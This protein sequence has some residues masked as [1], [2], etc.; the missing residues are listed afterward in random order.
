[1]TTRETAENGQ[2]APGAWWLA[3]IL[4]GLYPVLSL[5]SVNID[6]FAYGDTFRPVV[7]I[8]VVM[9]FLGTIFFVGLRDRLKASLLLSAFTFLFFSYGHAGEI[10]DRF[11][12]FPILAAVLHQMP[13]SPRF[14]LFS[15]CF[16]LF[17]A[18]AV[19]LARLRRNP[20]PAIVFANVVAAVL[21]CLPAVSILQTGI[22]NHGLVREIPLPP[23][24]PDPVKAALAADPALA[25]PKAGPT[26][27]APD[28]YYIILDAYG[29]ADVLEKFYGFS[30]RPFEQAMRRR[31]FYIAPRARPNYGQTACSICSS[32]N[33]MYLDRLARDVGRKSFGLSPL[34]PLIDHNAVERFL[35]PH[36]YK[37]VTVST[38]FELTNAA[39]ADVRL[40]EE[41]SEPPPLVT[42]FETLVLDVTPFAVIGQK[43]TTLFDRHRQVLSQAFV[44]L[45]NVPKIPHRKFVFAHILAPHPPFVFGPN[46]EPIQPLNRTFSL[47]DGSDFMHRGTAAEYR[48]LYIGQLQYINTCVLRAVDALYA[49]SKVRPIIIVQGDHGPRMFV[50]WE[51]LERTDVRETYGNLNAFSLPDGSASQVF[52]DDITPVNSFRL[53]LNH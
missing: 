38:G 48:K 53:L 8:A 30:N 16:A 43:E 32:L 27:Q 52:Y 13:L 33:M 2:T 7:V 19:W 11:G 26:T 24:S 42:A 10:A 46:G 12:G 41:L 3:P 28:I 47:A 31:G 4:F 49:K 23:A 51:S 36:G 50:D 1:M 20:A 44:D 15:F 6:D 22:R 45:G 17:A 34:T 40:G 14:I 21:C 9:T 35:R 39:N 37:F 18:F 25:D 29:R 5:Y